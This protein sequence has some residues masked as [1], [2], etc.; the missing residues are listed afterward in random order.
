ML[1]CWSVKG[2]VGTSTVAAGVALALGANGRC[3]LVDLG[4][5]QTHLFGV[6]P[7]PVPGVTE[8]MA[9]APDLAADALGR[10]EL[11]LAGGVAL[12]P[13]GSTALTD[14]GCRALAAAI[15]DRAE[16]VVVDAGGLGAAVLPAADRTLLVT[17]ACPVALAAVAAEPAVPSGVVVVRPRG[18]STSCAA[19][20]EAA[21]APV[22]AE[23]DL[24]PAVGR[25]VDA[26]L[27]LRPLPR[28][29]L[30]ALGAVA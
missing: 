5:D 30:R 7:G 27:A 22:V 28:G 12:L 23:L 8:W 3:L 13:R 21:G 25:A 26:G 4:G 15:A 17:R 14:D 20:G 19:I 2:G 24:D 1:V 10:L 16:P 29:Y 18:R 6:D 11:P 9:A